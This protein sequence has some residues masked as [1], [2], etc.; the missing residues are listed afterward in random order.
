MDLPLDSAA[1]M[2]TWCHS[3]HC[4]RT[5]SALPAELAERR[6]EIAER[7][8]RLLELDARLASSK[9]IWRPRSASC[10]WSQG[11]AMLLVSRRHRGGQRRL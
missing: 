11:R 6:A 1:R 2:A 5:T 3:G 8:R 9:V 4:E 7:I 10:R